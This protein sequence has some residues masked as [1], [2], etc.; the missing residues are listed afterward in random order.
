MLTKIFL[1]ASVL[2]DFECFSSEAVNGFSY[3]LQ[4]AFN[5]YFWAQLHSPVVYN[6]SENS[7]HVL[8]HL[9]SYK[10]IC[11]YFYCCYYILQH[12]ALH[13]TV[14]TSVFPPDFIS[15]SLSSV[16]SSG[17]ASPRYHSFLEFRDPISFTVQVTPI[18]NKLGLVLYTS[19]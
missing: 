7:T 14:M 12:S 2:L 8:S 19:I 17:I 3:C 16:I 5:F 11:I 4:L 13:W 10:H 6:I 1:K 9:R 18:I 15:L